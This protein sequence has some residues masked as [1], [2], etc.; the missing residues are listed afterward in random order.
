MC[1]P[2]MTD[3][4][5]SERRSPS[6]CPGSADACAANSKR[7]ALGGAPAGARGW[8]E[9]T[10]ISRCF[11]GSDVVAQKQGL[12]PPWP[13]RNLLSLTRGARCLDCP[14]PF[15]ACGHTSPPA[16][17]PI[18]RGHTSSRATPFVEWSSPSR[19]SGRV[20]SK[21]MLCLRAY[22]RLRCCRSVLGCLS[23]SNLRK[24]RSAA[25]RVEVCAP[26]WLK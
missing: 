8:S 5:L 1:H 2:T 22:H 10:A 14:A 16:S 24:N 7:G 25:G 11:H 23:V 21:L 6:S 12:V 18:A 9:E 26:H 3:S 13:A 17:H 15:I 20:R 19:R 4:P